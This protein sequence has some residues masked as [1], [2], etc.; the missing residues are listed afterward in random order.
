VEENLRD[1]M[2]EAVRG[3]IFL[4]SGNILSTAIL[5][6]NSILLARFLGPDRYGLYSLSLAL[7]SLLVLFSD[8]GIPPFLVRNMAS[9][10]RG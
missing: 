7:F 10:E 4:M 8:M 2:A 6:L 9:I 1:A 3:S 5:S